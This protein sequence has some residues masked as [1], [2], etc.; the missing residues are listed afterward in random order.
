MNSWKI[1][2]DENDTV[3]FEG[4]LEQCELAL[5][6]FL[7]DGIDAYLVE[8]EKPTRKKRKEAI[9]ANAEDIYKALKRLASRIDLEIHEVD[10]GVVLAL[11][12]ADKL[13]DKVESSYG[14]D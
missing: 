1:V 11:D 14:R 4:T 5:P 9:I 7:N 2:D 3:I 8:P 13:I 6:D 12:D 10:D